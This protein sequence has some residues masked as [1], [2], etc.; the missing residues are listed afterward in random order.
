MW[1]CIFRAWTAAL[2]TRSALLAPVRRLK[3]LCPRAAAVVRGGVEMQADADTLTPQDVVRLVPGE[4]IPV[5]GVVCS[6]TCT[7]DE[8]ALTG[9][10]CMEKRPRRSG[11]DDHGSGTECVR[12]DL[13]GV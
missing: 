11:H 1:L 6:S 8:S 13:S 10:H 5:D 9:M 2:L 12:Y 3:H 4:R 7:V